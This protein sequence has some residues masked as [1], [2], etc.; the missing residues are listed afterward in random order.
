MKM[1]A[2]GGVS[3]AL[4]ASN[5]KLTCCRGDFVVAD[6]EMQVYSGGYQLALTQRVQGTYSGWKTTALAGVGADAS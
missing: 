1:A 2:A 5:D 6:V 4:S 3:G